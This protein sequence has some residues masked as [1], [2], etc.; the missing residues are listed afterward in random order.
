MKAPSQEPS[1]LVK[2]P[3]RDDVKT[4]PKVAK[5]TKSKKTT[6]PKGR[7]TPSRK[8]QQAARRQPLVPEDRKAAKEEERKIAR[9][10]RAREQRALQT[11]D[12]RYLPLR[13]RGPQRR[14]IRDFVDA[15]YNVGDFVLIALVAVFFVTL[16]VARYQLIA[17]AIMWIIIL[18][19]VLD[20]WYVWRKIKKR[21]IAK[22][23]EVEPGSGMYT[24]NRVLMIRRLRLPKPQVKRGQYPA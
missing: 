10:N 9:E 3:A 14:F 16:F 12:E 15:R 1:K 22:F 21:L 20:T 4:S 6:Q 18:L 13:D 2:A 11:G 23:G 24:M 17:T 7:P 5:E 19:W 8:E